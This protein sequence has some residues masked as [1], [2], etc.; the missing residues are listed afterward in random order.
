MAEF[1]KQ[2]NPN[3][4]K[5]MAP[6]PLTPI[7]VI[8]QWVLIYNLSKW[9]I[10]ALEEML[11]MCVNTPGCDQTQGPQDQDCNENPTCL[12]GTAYDMQLI[13]DYYNADNQPNGNPLT[14]WYD[15]QYVGDFEL[16]LSNMWGA[17]IEGN[18]YDASLDGFGGWGLMSE[19]YY[20][21]DIVCTEGLSSCP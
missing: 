17:V 4:V 12:T 14:E 18:V 20:G 10:E 13:D 8:G 1:S 15:L 2:A 9:S 6:A 11:R 3:R 7:G 21:G 19:E 16:S 5:Q